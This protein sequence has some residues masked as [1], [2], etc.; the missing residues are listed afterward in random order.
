M[1]LISDGLNP[2]KPL[3]GWVLDRS[4]GGLYLSVP[5]RIDVGCRLAVRTPD[6]PDLVASVGLLVRHC[7][8][9]EPAN[10][11]AAS[12]AEELPWSVLLLF[13]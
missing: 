4:R 12:L 7:K 2:D 9:K 6:F 5:R 10:S 1:V 13:G 8:R 3:Q 11:H